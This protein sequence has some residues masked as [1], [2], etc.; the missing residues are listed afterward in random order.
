MNNSQYDYKFLELKSV[1]TWCLIANINNPKGVI[2]LPNGSGEYRSVF[3]GDDND[4]QLEWLNSMGYSAV[5]YDKYGC[6]ESEGDYKFL[7]M[8]IL[9]NQLSELSSEIKKITR[10]PTV[11]M[12]HSEGSII[13][14]EAAAKSNDICALIL[15]VASHQKIKERLE[16]QLNSADKSGKSY[17][18]WITGIK[19]IENNLKSNISFSGFL[20]SHPKTYWASRLNRPLTGDVIKDINIPVFAL[21]GDSDYYTPSNCFFEIHRIIKDHHKLSKAKIYSGVGH[22]LRHQG[23]SYGEAEADKDIINWINEVI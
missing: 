8:D 18:N 12:G 20:S 16:F 5:K 1:K 6:G 4:P 2:I 14:A 19:E 22:S 7:T 10:L 21:N 3:Q 13:A 9:V 17:N 23:Q 11:V 15:R